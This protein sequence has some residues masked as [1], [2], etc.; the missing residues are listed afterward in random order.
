[1]KDKILFFKQKFQNLPKIVQCI[2]IVLLDKYFA[3][4]WIGFIFSFGMYLEKKF[5]FYIESMSFEPL[6][7]DGKSISI[8][9]KMKEFIQQGAY[10]KIAYILLII[11]IIEETVFRHFLKRNHFGL[12]LSLAF[13]LSVSFKIAIGFDSV[14]IIFVGF[15][16]V[17]VGYA[18]KTY[19]EPW[20]AYV[21]KHITFFYVL[22]SILFGLIHNFNFY[23]SFNIA[24]HLNPAFVMPQIMGGFLYGYA[25]M[26]LGFGY[27][28]LC[29]TLA[30][31]IIFSALFW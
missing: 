6:P 13:F 30:N 14:Y 25:R 3:L 11:P 21:L 22:S 17:A 7:D 20:H 16:L 28:V 27:G 18:F 5:G 24:T 26:H 10:F 19:L 31:G 29:H 15:A 8:F 23:S 12:I 9:G 2:L 4:L 1:M